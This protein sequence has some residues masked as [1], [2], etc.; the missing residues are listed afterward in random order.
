MSLEVRGFLATN[1]SLDCAGPDDR[2]LNQTLLF[3]V[4][5]FYINKDDKI[6]IDV[7]Q[8]HLKARCMLSLQSFHSPVVKACSVKICK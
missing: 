3:L 2:E 7:K 8:N 4:I 6:F 5:L 1:P